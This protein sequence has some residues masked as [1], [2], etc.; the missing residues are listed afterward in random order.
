MLCPGPCGQSRRPEGHQFDT[1]IGEFNGT[2]KEAVCCAHCSRFIRWA[3]DEG[4]AA[5]Q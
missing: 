3:E 2:G 5:T 1:F 4:K